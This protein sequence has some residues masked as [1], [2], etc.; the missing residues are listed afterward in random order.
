MGQDGI[1]YIQY[2]KETQLLM[3]RRLPFSY[4]SDAS[5]ATGGRIVTTLADMEGNETFDKGALGEADEVRYQLLCPCVY[6]TLT[7]TCMYRY[8]SVS[9]VHLHVSIRDILILFVTYGRH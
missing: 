4:T 7:Y 2:S 8:T 3:R 1:Q 6:G 5:Q 9:R